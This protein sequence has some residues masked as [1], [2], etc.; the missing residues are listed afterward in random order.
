MD[1]DVE[2]EL[3]LETERQKKRRK[4]AAHGHEHLVCTICGED[5]VLCL[6]EDHVAGRK[7]DDALRLI[8]E[9]C[10][11]KRTADQRCDPPPGPN[12]RN[13][14]E[15]IGRWLLSLATYFDLLK[16]TLRRFGLFLIDL[17]KQGYGDEFA[18]P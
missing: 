6:I 14:F 18:F 7:Y 8:C 17:A 12:P 15:V 13:P 11:C 3:Q 4:F 9:N 2:R 1:A 10:D 5:E 16:D